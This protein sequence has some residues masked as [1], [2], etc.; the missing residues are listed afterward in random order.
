[1]LNWGSLGALYTYDSMLAPTYQASQFVTATALQV[2]VIA[3]S[4][5]EQTSA[6]TAYPT[7]T[8]FVPP[9]T[10]QPAIQEQVQPTALDVQRSVCCYSTPGAMAVQK[11]PDQVVVATYASSSP[12]AIPPRSVTTM[13]T[14]PNVAPMVLLKKRRPWMWLAIAVAMVGAGAAIA[15]VDP[16]NP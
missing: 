6:I 13:E 3:P 2:E 1:M 11:E 8:I 12:D 16:P 10:I 15:Q 9:P 7:E 4:T 14:I 5:I